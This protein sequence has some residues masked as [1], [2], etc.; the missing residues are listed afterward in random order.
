MIICY[1]GTPGSGKTYDAVIKIIANLKKG[2][3]VYTNIDGLGDPVR[4]EQ[5]M[6]RAGLTEVQ[7]DMQLIHWDTS[8][9]IQDKEKVY[10]FMEHVEPRSYIIIDEIHKYFNC[11]DWQTE[12]NRLFAE[13]GSTHR[14]FGFDL[15]M[16]TQDYEK[17]D[18]QVRSLIEYTY[19][20]RKINFMGPGIKNKFIVYSYSGE[21]VGRY[22]AKSYG[23]YDKSIF[24]CYDSYVTRDM[25]ELPIQA[26]ANIFRHPVFYVIPVLLLIFVALFLESGF[27]K[28]EI[29][30]GSHAAMELV[31]KREPVDSTNK[32]NEQVGVGVNKG[33]RPVVIEYSELQLQAKQNIPSKQVNQNISSKQVK[34]NTS[35]KQVKQD[36]PFKEPV[37]QSVSLLESS[38]PFLSQSSVFYPKKLLGVING[39]KVYKSKDGFVYS[40]IAF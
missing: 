26:H 24:H 32:A 5:I 7:L 3:K 16:I 39:K 20:Y 35:F 30:P 37:R 33:T 18:K 27:S 29:I 17:I 14:H 22:I 8:N 34:Q 12:K 23:T 31:K 1:Q 19:V 6:R 13:W 21:P 38:D 11:R 40:D 4:R 28:G 2:R 15:L 10:N 25:K 9:S 36:I